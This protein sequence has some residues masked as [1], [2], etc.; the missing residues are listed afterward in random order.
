M[1]QQEFLI[2]TESAL[3]DLKKSLSDQQ[4]ARAKSEEKYQL[5]LA[6]MEK[7]KA[8]LKRAQADQD[9]STKRAEKVEAKL[10]TVQQELSG[11]KRRISNMAQAVFG[12][13]LK[14]LTFLDK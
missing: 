3:G 7:L 5:V 6:E 10:A 1:L 13:I 2:Q 8:D 9:A 4:D 11:L 14:P 12:K